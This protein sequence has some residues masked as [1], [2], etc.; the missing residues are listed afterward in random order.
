MQNVT[1]RLSPG[2]VGPS[3]RRAIGQVAYCGADRGA[4]EGRRY[5]V[6]SDLV[7]TIASPDENLVATQLALG[8]RSFPV[9]IVAGMEKLQAGRLFILDHALMARWEKIA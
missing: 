5:I 3:V 9:K 7:G 6:W 1:G 4:P 2:S 8:G